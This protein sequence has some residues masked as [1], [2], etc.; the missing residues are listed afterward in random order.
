MGWIDRQLEQAF[1]RRG[2][3]R[4]GDCREDRRRASQV[5]PTLIVGYEYRWTDRTNIN[6]Q[7]YYSRSAYSD[8][9]SHLE[10]LNG[11][12]YQMTLGF[13][14]RRGSV[15]YTFGVTENLQNINNTSDIGFQLG[16][17]FIPKMLSRGH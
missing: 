11:E 12:K 5:I 15:L 8:R 1:A 17:A 3:D 2:E 14:H 10:E 6:L 13:R 7:A 16:I 9:T 4:V